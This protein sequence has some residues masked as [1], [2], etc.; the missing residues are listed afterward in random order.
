MFVVRSRSRSRSRPR[1][2]PSF[3]INTRRLPRSR[4]QP[5]SLSTRVRPYSLLSC[6]HVPCMSASASRLAVASDARPRPSH[7]TRGVVPSIV[8]H[9]SN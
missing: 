4:P 8:R 7:P 6:R 9:Q 5:I 2:R 1:S 3:S